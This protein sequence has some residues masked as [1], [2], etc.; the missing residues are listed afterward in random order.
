MLAHRSLAR[1]MVSDKTADLLI[2]SVSLN[3]LK[4]RSTLS[5]EFDCA[6]LTLY[7][8][9]SAGNFPKTLV[10]SKVGLGEG[11]RDGGWM[12]D[13]KRRL[14]AW[15]SMPT[16]PTDSVGPVALP[17]LYPT[18]QKC[19]FSLW[20]VPHSVCSNN[21]TKN[22]TRLSRSPGEGGRDNLS[23]YRT[24]KLSILALLFTHSLAHP[25]Q[26][27]PRQGKSVPSDSCRVSPAPS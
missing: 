21:P 26:Q 10:S 27:Q 2:S 3:L 4:S 8:K 11:T 17:S 6:D 13:T 23:N 7:F 14:P 1:L 22:A 25:T 12:T 15:Q 19:R 18:P 24:R 16:K 20:L 5:R 9:W